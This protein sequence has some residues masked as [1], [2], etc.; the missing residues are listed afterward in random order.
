MLDG[1]NETNTKEDLQAIQ[2]WPLAE[3]REGEE[4]MRKARDEPTPFT[5]EEAS[6]QEEYYSKRRGVTRELYDEMEKA[7]TQREYLLLRI[8][9]VKCLSNKMK[10]GYKEVLAE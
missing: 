7:L 1:K 2:T 10:A 6:F 3:I 4:M 8:I 9:R 5:E